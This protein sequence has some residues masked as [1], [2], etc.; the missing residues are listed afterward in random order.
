MTVLRPAFMAKKGIQSTPP[1]VLTVV[2]SANMRFAQGSADYARKYT[3]WNHIVFEFGSR[4]QF[5][6]L[7]SHMR[8]DGLIVD[9][10]FQSSLLNWMRK[11][12]IPFVLLDW[13]GLEEDCHGVCVDQQKVGHRAFDYLRAK[14]FNQFGFLGYKNLRVI[15][16]RYEGFFNAAQSDGFSVQDFWVSSTNEPF[17]DSVK[18]ARFTSW[19]QGL[20]KPAAIFAGADF[21]AHLVRLKCVENNLQIPHQVSILGVDNRPVWC[22]I[23]EPELSSIPLPLYHIGEKGAEILGRVLKKRPS[24][25]IVELLEPLPVVPRTS[26]DTLAIHDAKMLKALRFIHDNFDQQIT[27]KDVAAHAGTSVQVLNRKMHKYLKRSTLKEINMHRLEKAAHQLL[28]LRQTIQDVSE[29][30][31]INSVQWFCRIFERTYGVPPG[32]YRRE[33]AIPSASEPADATGPFS[34][35]WD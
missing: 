23:A 7:L 29:S 26:T 1:T 33:N 9:I 21:L 11:K 4:Q 12:P 5:K 3:N 15:Q 2:Q 20:K 34:I 6:D 28:D 16:S 30:C 17:I 18:S 35:E 31:G 10:P 24:K 32:R 13:T 27:V 19:L 22:T 14:G 8:P 25:S